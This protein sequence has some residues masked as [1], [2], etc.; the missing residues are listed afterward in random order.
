MVINAPYLS[1]AGGTTAR[2]KF[3]VV[4]INETAS[5]DL[6]P[7]ITLYA[8][9]VATA[10]DVSR[11]LGVPLI[12][13]TH[14]PVCGDTAEWCDVLGD[15]PNATLSHCRCEATTPGYHAQSCERSPLRRRFVIDYSDPRLTGV[16]LYAGNA[17]VRHA[18]VL[19]ERGAL[20]IGRHFLNTGEPRLPNGRA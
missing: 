15:R 1:I 10:R 9:A 6:T 14:C 19:T 8:V 20:R 17:I 13:P 4:K 12:L 16:I 3:R 11:I 7:E 5:D 2:P 18:V